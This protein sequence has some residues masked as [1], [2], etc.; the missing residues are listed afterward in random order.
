MRDDYKVKSQGTKLH[1]HAALYNERMDGIVKLRMPFDS[2]NLEALMNQET[3][4]LNPSK[5]DCVPGFPCPWQEETS[6]L[7]DSLEESWGLLPDGGLGGGH[8]CPGGS[9]R[10]RR[11]RRWQAL[12]LEQT[13]SCVRHATA[14]DGKKLDPDTN[15]QS[16]REQTNA[17]SYRRRR[18]TQ[19]TGRWSV[20]IS[21]TW[22]VN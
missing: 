22:A 6:I 2:N 21:T 3:P 15:Q 17:N 20:A 16:F 13:S 11:E 8:E 5:S 4:A 14:G 7:N 18:G 1:C 12:Q 9:E 10:E 19:D